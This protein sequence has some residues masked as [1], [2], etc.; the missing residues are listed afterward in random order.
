MRR[1]RGPAKES[2]ASPLPRLRRA[3]YDAH[4]VFHC[5]LGVAAR[6]CRRET[7]RQM[8][9]QSHHRHLTNAG[10]D[11]VELL[12]DVETVAVVGHHLLN[13]A[14]LTLQFP[15][16]QQDVFAWARTSW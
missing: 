3:A 12:Q 11:G 9:L 16:A 2:R 14:D 15:Q 1:Q 10:G 4:H 8:R 5:T 13:A 6:Y 7:A